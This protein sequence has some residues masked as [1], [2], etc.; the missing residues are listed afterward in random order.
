[1][2]LIWLMLLMLF[3]FVDVVEFIDVLDI[4]CGEGR[5]SVWKHVNMWKRKAYRAKKLLW[6]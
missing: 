5:G 1:M 3:M 6:N 4:L 2:L